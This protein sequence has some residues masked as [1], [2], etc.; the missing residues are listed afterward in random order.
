[1]VQIT[2]HLLKKSATAWALSV[3]RR[4]ASSKWLAVGRRIGQKRRFRGFFNRLADYHVRLHSAYPTMY[5]DHLSWLRTHD[6]PSLHPSQRPWSLAWR[7][8]A[9]ICTAKHNLAGVYIY[10]FL[11]LRLLLRV[12]HKSTPI[13]MTCNTETIICHSSGPYK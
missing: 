13:T 4:P 10:C 2:P 8:G 11:A 6:R 9:N 1:M 12:A 3:Y 5:I 7:R